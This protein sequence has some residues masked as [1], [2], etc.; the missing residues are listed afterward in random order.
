MGPISPEYAAGFFDGEGSV[1]LEYH[2]SARQKSWWRVT[3]TVGQNDRRPLDLLADRW[4]GV[5]SERSLPHG[6]F[7]EW[8]IHTRQAAQFLR[9]IRPWLIVKAEQTDIL[10]EFQSKIGK[11]PGVKGLPDYERERRLDLSKRLRLVKAQK[12]RVA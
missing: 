5:V 2:T 9:D 12:G 6:L 8:R 7:Y 4:G 3:A 11:S 1:I 10:L